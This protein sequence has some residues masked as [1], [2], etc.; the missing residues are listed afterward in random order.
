LTVAG[1]LHG[2]RVLEF[3]ALGPVPFACMLLSDMGADVVTVDRPQAG[4][5]DARHVVWRG[6]TPVQLDL[7][8]PQGRADAAGLLAHADVLVEGFRPGVMERLGLG[9]EVALQAN[10]ALVYARMTGWGQDGPL[11]PRAGHDINYI[12]LTGALHAIGP[13]E[14]PVP[15]LNLLGDYGGGSLYLV[16][17]SSRRCTSAGNRVAGRWSTRRSSTA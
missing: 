4:R 12:A 6:R 17:A 7:K 8:A 11:A 1:P 9:P 16:T 13:R 3:A 2:L 5:A 15:P 10:P 14:R